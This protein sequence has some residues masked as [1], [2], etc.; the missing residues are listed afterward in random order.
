MATHRTS[1]SKALYVELPEDLRQRLDDFV[2]RTRRKFKGEV[3]N[4]IEQ[5]LDR[6]E[7]STAPKPRPVASVE[8]LP[9]K[10][11]GRPRKEG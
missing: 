9:A 5:Y 10:R 7:G 2:T 8:T 1:K 11:R 4:A 3:V 6:E